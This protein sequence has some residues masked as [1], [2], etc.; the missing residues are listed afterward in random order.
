MAS[1]WKVPSPP[2][3]DGALRFDDRARA[4]AADDFGGL[5]HRTPEGVLFPGSDGDVAATVR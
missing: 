1:T 5:V 4:A 2:P 3:V